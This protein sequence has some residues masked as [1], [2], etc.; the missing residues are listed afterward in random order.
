MPASGE[1]RDTNE[2]AA[3][4]MPEPSPSSESGRINADRPW[5]IALIA[6]SILLIELAFIRLIPAEVRAISYFRNL[7]L[8]AAFFGLGV[9]CILQESRSLELLLPI[10]LMILGTLMIVGRGIVIYPQSSTVHYWLMYGDM[11]ERPQLPLS[12]AAG[13][14]FVSCAVPFAALGQSLAREMSRHERLSAYGWDLAGSLGGVLIFVLA[15]AAR[16]PPWLWPCIVMVVWSVVFVRTAL[17]R[18]LYASAGLI[19]LGFSLSQQESMWSPYYLVQFERTPVGTRVFVNSGFHQF[20]F[21]FNRQSKDPVPTFDDIVKK[22][23]MPY[24]AYRAENQG[25]D[26]KR[27]LVLGAGTGNDVAIALANGASE[28]TAVEIDPVILEVGKQSNAKWLFTDPRVEFQIDD[29]RRFLRTADRR[30]DMIIFGTLDSHILLA[31][32]GN[33][34]LENYVYTQ[35]SL[36]DARRLLVDRGIAAVFYCVQKDWLY[37]RIYSTFRA[38]FGDQSRMHFYQN[39][40]LFNTIL[41]GTKENPTFRDNGQ[42]VQQ[43]GRGMVATDDWPFVYLRRP[44]VAQCMDH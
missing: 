3:M 14:L 1:R 28:V 34:R 41:L 15:S 27:V 32:Q 43:F 24:D 13:L 16:F 20:G 42:M 30:F 4:T 37:E 7:I 8:M 31:A 23:N 22:W 36:A 40:D 9:G 5:R 10:G 21:D 17:C 35:E 29:A 26:P 6:G 38:A 33:I 12:L 19:F 18:L 2:N 11:H 25:R 44:S 39:Q